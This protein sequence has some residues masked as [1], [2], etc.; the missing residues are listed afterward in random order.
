MPHRWPV[1]ENPHLAPRAPRDQLDY[2]T[3]SN[4]PLVNSRHAVLFAPYMGKSRFSEHMADLY[5]E[6]GYKVLRVSRHQD[7]V[8]AIRLGVEAHRICEDELDRR[9]LESWKE[10]LRVWRV[11][12]VAALVFMFLAVVIAGGLGVFRHG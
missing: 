1:D 6:A 8:D 12:F 11:R 5:E 10:F 3:R 4:A 7:G 2:E 9:A